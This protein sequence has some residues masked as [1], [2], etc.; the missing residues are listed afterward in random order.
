MPKF[1]VTHTMPP[2]GIS[3]EQFC[4]VSEASQ[5][6]PTV[7]GLQ[8]YANLTEGK[9]FC[10]WEAPQKEAIAAWFKKME[11]PFDSITRLELE[12]QAGAVKDP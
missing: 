8:S 6:D 5:K 12:G 7:K 1:M 9:I 10:L 2:K 3:R 11:V 4:Q